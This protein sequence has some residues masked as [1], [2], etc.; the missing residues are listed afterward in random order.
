[1]L[2]YRR[3]VTTM[4]FAGHDYWLTGGMSWGETPTDA[5][6]RIAALDRIGLYEEPLPATGG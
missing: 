2:G 4:Q 6:E 3:D 5:Y 1:V